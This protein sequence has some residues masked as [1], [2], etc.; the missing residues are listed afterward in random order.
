MKG[1]SIGKSIGT[2]FGIFWAGNGASLVR[3]KP[4]A[5]NQRAFTNHVLP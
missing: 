3:G 1:V 5:F 4:G 2:S